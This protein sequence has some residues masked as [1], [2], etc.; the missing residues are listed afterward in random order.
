[1]KVYQK[2]WQAFGWNAIIVHGHNINDIIKAFEKARNHKGAPTVLLAETHKGKYFGGNID[3]Q[4]SWHG[5]PLGTSSAETIAH[6]K[7][8]IKNLDAKL[9]PKLPDIPQWEEKEHKPINLPES[10]DYVKGILTIKD[11]FTDYILFQ[12]RKLLQ[13]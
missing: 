5:K 6:L 10:L 9:E 12:V 7:T 3:N 11:Y 4:L 13:E 1:M 2:K 8:L